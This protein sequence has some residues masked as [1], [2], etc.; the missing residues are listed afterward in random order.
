L[1]RRESTGTESESG[2]PA[3]GLGGSLAGRDG[4][5]PEGEGAAEAVDGYRAL[6]EMS[7]R[8]ANA[9]D[10]GDES[11]DDLSGDEGLEEMLRQRAAGAMPKEETV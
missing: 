7:Q 9:D 10:D 8:L 4:S 3:P 1:F 5:G 6:R 2:T 11:D